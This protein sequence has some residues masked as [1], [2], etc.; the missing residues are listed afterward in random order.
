L[1]EEVTIDGSFSQSGPGIQYQ[2][3]DQSDIPIP[4]ANSRTL[5]VTI[6]G[7]YIFESVDTVTGCVNRDTIEVNEDRLF[8]VADAGE[9]QIIKCDSTSIILNASGSTQQN[10]IDYTWNKLSGAGNIIQGNGTLFPEVD[11]KGFFELQVRD[12]VTG[13]TS[14]DTVF[15]DQTFAPILDRLIVQNEQCGGEENGLIDVIG[16][17]GIRPFEYELNGRDVDT[18]VFENLKPGLFFFRVTDS[19]GC[20][21][22]TLLEVKEGN[23]FDFRI[24]GDTFIIKGDSTTLSIDINIPETEVDQV[25]WEEDGSVFCFRCYSVTVKPDTTTLYDFRLVDVNGCEYE[26]SF[27]VRVQEENDIYVPNIFTPNGDTNNEVMQVFGK[28]LVNIDNLMIFNRWGELVFKGQNLPPG[29]VWDGRWNGDY[30]VPAVL[31]YMIDAQFKDGSFKKF[32]GSIT[33]L[34]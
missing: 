10:S 20:F 25:Y 19:L 12:R 4:G 8:H 21:T 2:W 16:I 18:T 28:N 34:R 27:L 31:T 17:R 7:I 11:G 24:Q 1:Q 9:D 5:N 26:F 15:V 3:F 33:L 30:H 22:D 29:E 6:P 14:R 23:Y 13:C 32:T